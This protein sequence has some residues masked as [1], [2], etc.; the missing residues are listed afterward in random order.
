ML[1]NVEKKCYQQSL[2][3]TQKEQFKQKDKEGHKLC[4]TII[5]SV[6]HKTFLISRKRRNTKEMKKQQESKIQSLNVLLECMQQ[7]Y[8]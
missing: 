3:A 6:A 1:T 5:I 8:I 7:L 4:R 2:S